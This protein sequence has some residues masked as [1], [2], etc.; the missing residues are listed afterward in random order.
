MSPYGILPQLKFGLP[1]G[2][3]VSLAVGD[4]CLLMY[5]IETGN[6]SMTCGI[7]TLPF[8]IAPGPAINGSTIGCSEW[9]IPST[10]TTFKASK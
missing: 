6:T 7:H 9:G 5:S 4:D 1:N 3:N 8:V 10:N 2:D